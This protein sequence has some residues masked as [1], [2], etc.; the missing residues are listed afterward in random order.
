V[1]HVGDRYHPEHMLCEHPG[2]PRCRERLSGDYYEVDGR[3]LCERHAN[4]GRH[5]D[6]N[7]RWKTANAMKRTTRMIT[8][9]RNGLR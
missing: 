6:G 9:G 2:Y 4:S 7:D 1:S 8:L 3:M 5:N